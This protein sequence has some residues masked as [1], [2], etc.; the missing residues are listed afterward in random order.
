MNF[1]IG[2]IAGGF[3]WYIS[4]LVSGKFE[5]FDS[6][7]GFYASQV[8]LSVITFIIGYKA[9]YLVLQTIFGI[10][11]GQVL[12]AYM[13]GSSE[14]RAWIYLGMI[15]IIALCI[16]PLISGIIGVVLR[17]IKIKKSDNNKT[18]GKAK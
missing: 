2:I 1:I 3:G 7:V 9:S 15:T 12:Y 16:F 11:I 5:P 13:F 14:T 8:F 10:Y 18:I 17:E 6:D 4:W